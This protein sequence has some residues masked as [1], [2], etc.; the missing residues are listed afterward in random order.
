MT[1]PEALD[2]YPPG[3]GPLF[4]R[5]AEVFAEDP[6]VRGMW[7]HGA[8]AR[9]EAD[10]GSDLDI[11]LAVADDAFDAFTGEWT[12]WLAA[13]T[14]TVSAVPLGGAPGSCYALTPTCER[15]DVLCERVS[16]L[17]TSGL[18]RRLTVFDRDGLTRLIPAPHDPD[19]DPE[20]VERLIREVLR[21]A[22]NFPTVVVRDDWLLGVVAVQQVHLMLY[23]LFAEADKPRPLTGPK[24]WQ[25]K[26]SEEHRRILRALPV[27][28]PDAASVGAARTAALGLFLREAPRIA[29]ACKAP[30]PDDLADAV[31]GYLAREGYSVDPA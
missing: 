25:T 4:E 2:V 24:Q 10:A 3:Y 6:R 23:E 15:L 1:R 17:P 22:A 18:T 31:L 21:Q 19:P 26:L 27:P 20:T 28:Q 7:L 9:G 13:I 5:A 29:A 11:D 8:I 30:W 16:A 14:P 12:R